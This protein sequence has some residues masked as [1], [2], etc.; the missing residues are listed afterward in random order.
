MLDDHATTFAHNNNNK[1][2]LTNTKALSPN[3][4]NNNKFNY[5]YTMLTCL[6]SHVMVVTQQLMVETRTD[7]MTTKYG[8][9][10]YGNQ[11]I[12]YVNLVLYIKENMFCSFKK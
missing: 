6:M 7:K 1:I 4:N 8:I 3:N 5:F 2:G 9:K 10:L 11:R 12:C